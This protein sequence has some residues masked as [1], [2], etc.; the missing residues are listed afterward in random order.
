MIINL[1]IVGPH[2][3]TLF[4]TTPSQA[5]NLYAVIDQPLSSSAGLL[6]MVKCIPVKG[7]PQLFFCKFVNLE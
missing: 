7:C 3:D 4:V 5:S 2:L 1:A 6:F